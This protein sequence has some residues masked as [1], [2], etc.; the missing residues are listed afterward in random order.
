MSNPSFRKPALIITT[1]VAFAVGVMLIVSF[2]VNRAEA[3]SNAMN[4]YDGKPAGYQIN[5]SG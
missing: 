2:N 3:E 5:D 1:A 4:Y